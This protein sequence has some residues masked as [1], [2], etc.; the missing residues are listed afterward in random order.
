MSG[1]KKPWLAWSAVIA[2]LLFAIRPHFAWITHDHA[3]GD[4]SHQH[5]QLSFHDQ[6]VLGAVLNVFPV[7]ITEKTADEKAYGEQTAASQADAIAENQ[8][9]AHLDLPIGMLGFQPISPTAHIH[10]VEMANLCAAIFL[11][12]LIAASVKLFQRLPF[13]PPQAPRRLAIR[14]IARGPPQLFA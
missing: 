3:A 13:T 6:G 10:D 11:W 7:S 5:A 9:T 8:A 14:A 4:T 1:V 12:M 2:L